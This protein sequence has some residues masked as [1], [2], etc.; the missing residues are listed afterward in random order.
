[1]QRQLHQSVTRETCSGLTAHNVSA[2]RAEERCSTLVCILPVC[3]T[4]KPHAARPDVVTSCFAAQVEE[5]TPFDLWDREGKL[6]LPAEDEAAEMMAFASETLR[7]AGFEHYELSNYAQR[8]HRCRHNM[9]YW[10]GHG[11]YAFGL[12]AA[13]FVQGRRFSRPRKLAAWRRWVRGMRD[14]HRDGGHGFLSGEG[15]ADAEVRTEADRML[16]S[17]ML[18]LR[19]A[20]GIELAAFADAFGSPALVALL[21]ALQPHAASGLVQ[22]SAGAQLDGDRCSHVNEQGAATERSGERQLPS[23]A[24]VAALQQRGEAVRVRLADPA[25]LML[26]NSIIS[27]VF[28]ALES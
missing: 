26:S 2:A 19:L 15:L 27:D 18:Q 8:G 10:L 7:G 23:A 13:S 24:E 9:V 6:D 3:C 14:A 5:G 25:G 22:V 11:Y 1:M 28:V 17:V 16:E 4:S 21:A 12:G 20:D